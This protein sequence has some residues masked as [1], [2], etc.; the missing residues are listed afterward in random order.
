MVTLEQ[1]FDWFLELEEFKKLDS[2]ARMNRQVK[3]LRRL[4]D[5]RQLIR[6]LSIP[7]L[8]NFL[9]ERLQEPSP[10]KL[11]SLIAP[12]TA[13]EEINLLRNILNQAL[14]HE[15]IINFDPFSIG[16]S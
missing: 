13:M 14:R 2:Y 10:S 5:S 7:S 1:L 3:A 12:K 6:D 9:Q 15:I 16:Q 4:L 8:E 11:G